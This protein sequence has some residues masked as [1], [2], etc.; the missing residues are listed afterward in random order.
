MPRRARDGPRRARAVARRHDDA[1]PELPQRVERGGRRRLHRV[2]GCDKAGD[3]AVDRDE[4]HRFASVA[5]RVHR[6]RRR[7]GGDAE[8][9]QQREV[10][11][12][13]LPAVDDAPD[14]LAGQ[15]LEIR[16]PQSA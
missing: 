5:P 10:A 15:R 9:L 12:R 4:H 3:G 16:R 2:R 7:P 1:N 11:E 8:L 6:G 14:A 13:D